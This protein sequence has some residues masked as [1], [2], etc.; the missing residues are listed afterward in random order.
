MAKTNQRITDRKRVQKQGVK[1]SSEP[2]PSHASGKTMRAVAR[3]EEKL[4]IMAQKKLAAEKKQAAG[5]K[6]ATAKVVVDEAED[7]DL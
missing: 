6:Q 2:G 7:V 5:K 4:K 3:K 1:Q